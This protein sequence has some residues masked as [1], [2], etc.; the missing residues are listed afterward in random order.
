MAL[1]HEGHRG[2]ELMNAL[3]PEQRA[4]ARVSEDLPDGIYAGPGRKDSLSEFEGLAAEAMNEQQMRLLR[5]LV[6]EYVRN[7][8]FDAADAQLDAIAAAGWDAVHF[9]WRGPVDVDGR[10]YY[11]VH[12][13]R[14]LIEYNRVDVN[15]DHSI[16]R[17]PANDYG[18]DWLGKHM[19]EHHPS[20]QE[21]RA[22]IEERTGIDLPD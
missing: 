1:S 16:V 18:A 21:I 12:G 22:G 14:V 10:F 13:P 3:T 6:D 11:R 17:D 4:I 19:E 5:V 2:V 20:Q 15:H 8:D 7:A 9:S